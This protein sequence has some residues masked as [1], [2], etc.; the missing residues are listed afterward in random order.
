MSHRVDVII[1]CH[2][3]SRPVGRAVA[4]VLD[5]NREDV[6][7]TVVCHNVAVDKIRD[8][9]AER[10][11]SDV[12]F[13]HLEDGIRSASGPFEH[14]T[15]H[16]TGEF[17]SILG[18]DDTLQPGA[19]REWLDL[20]QDTGAEV[21]ITRLL[22]EGRVVHTPPARPFH[23]GL[24]DPVRDRLSYRSAPLGLVSRAARERTGARLVAGAQV[25]G[26][27]PYVTELWFGAKTAVQRSGP[28]YNIGE[29][30]TDRV[31]YNPRPIADE[32]SFIHTL[33]DADWYR[34]LAA[35]QRVA[36]A[37]KLLRIHVFGVITNR[38]GPS[39]WTEEQRGALARAAG[40]VVD[41]APG[42]LDRLSIADNRVVEAIRNQD[43]PAET[44]IELAHA[45]RR[46]GMPLTLVPR[47]LRM[48]FAR[49]APLRFMAASLL[50]R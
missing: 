37:A 45:R 43:V 14:G 44:L 50:T 5:G 36:I 2:S 7:L 30:A 24:A 13:L 38:P 10:H 3:P 21:V 39:W 26:D 12:T 18:S 35:D 17:V 25:G 46:H 11:L 31:T 33:L 27:V 9:I 8:V 49:E 28:G 34:Q 20:A 48:L 6:R 16:A 4:S 22:L 32:F 15:A 1:A 42:V 40:R 19:V 41:S 23:R 47:S 29:S